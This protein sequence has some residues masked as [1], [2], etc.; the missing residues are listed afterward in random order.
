MNFIMKKLFYIILMAPFLF[1][2]CSDELDKDWNNPNVYQPSPDEVVSGLFT[3]MQKTRFWMKD[4]GEWYWLLSNWDQDFGAVAQVHVYVPYSTAYCSFWADDH[5]G[6]AENFIASANGNIG[7]KFERFYT[8]LTNYGLI[9]DEVNALSGAELDETVIYKDLSTVLKNVVAT[10]TVDLFNKIPYFNAFRGS[11]AIFFTPY[12]DP[13]EIYKSVIEEYQT[14]AKGLP[15]VYAK[16][17][18]LAK[19]KLETQDIFFH[20]DMNKWV[21]YINVQTLKS[22]VRISGVAADYV[23]PIIAEAIKSL[24]T[25]DFTFTS[26]Q[27]NENRIGTSAGGIIQ[28]GFYE[29]YYQLAVPDVIML[30]MNRGSEVYDKNVDDPRLPVITM[31]FTRDGTADAVEY[32]G[33]SGNWDRNKYLRGLPAET[34]LPLDSLRRANVYPQIGTASNII[35]PNNSMDITV[36][37][38]PWTYYNPITFVLGET[39]LHIFTRGETDLLLAEVALKNLASTG[40]S[41]GQ[42]IS[43]AIKHSTDFWYFVNS[44]PHYAGTMSDVTKQIL[45]PAKPDASIIDA[46]AATVQGEFD[47]AAGEEAKMEI[48][49]QQK[50]IHLNILEPFEL[51]TE[52]RRTRHPK[53]EPITCTGTSE[54]LVNATMMIERF[55]L[56][57]SERTNNYDEYTKIMAEDKWGNPVFWVPADKISEKYFLPEALKAPLP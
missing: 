42:H 11:E 48:L 3:H 36:Q 33:V 30:R 44:S 10:Q 55:K 2:S 13:L 54:T 23:K 46:Y 21:Q 34:E 4:Y 40:K 27:V 9:R 57:T 24:P 53:L 8:D 39:P 47:A 52:L 15:G 51:F 12:D 26:P 29:Q 28:R 31:G 43:D 56:P 32:Y 22:C 20:G 19:S 7:G 50:Y 37:G 5:Y 16:M 41:A 18:D 17:S 25:E 6:D 1:G 49:M 45:T 38:V 35:R 14:I